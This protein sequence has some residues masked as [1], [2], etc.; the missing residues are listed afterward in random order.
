[1]MG[2]NDNIKVSRKTAED[3]AQVWPG[4]GSRA[5]LDQ[6]VKGKKPFEKE[7]TITVTSDSG[8]ESEVTVLFR[9]IGGNSYD[10]LVSQYPPNREQKQEGM[11]F[12]IDRFAP[13]LISKCAI[14]PEIPLDDAKELWNSDA[15]N[16]GERMA[17]FLGAVECCTKGLDIPFG[18]GV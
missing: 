2:E 8:E 5:T 16:R 17:L 12:N 18:N 1:M 13:V 11:T 10:K 3:E 9:A 7:V 14:E 6:L 4:G 15:W